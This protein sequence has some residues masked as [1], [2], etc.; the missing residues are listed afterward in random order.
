MKP[1]ASRSNTLHV[2]TAFSSSNRIKIYKG[3]QGRSYK[4]KNNL[5]TNDVNL[6]LRPLTGVIIIFS[7]INSLTMV[8]REHTCLGVK[9]NLKIDSKFQVVKISSLRDGVQS[10][11]RYRKI[12]L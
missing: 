7:S 1:N 2:T 4:I 11:S 10:Q 12:F 8:S 5:V 3:S 6:Y 9:A